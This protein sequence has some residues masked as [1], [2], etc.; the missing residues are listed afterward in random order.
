MYSKY[1]I[2]KMLEIQNKFN[3]REY[4]DNWVKGI[5]TNK[6]RINLGR[7]IYMKASGLMNLYHWEWDTYKEV[8]LNS[9]VIIYEFIS[10]LSFVISSTMSEVSFRGDNIIE[11][12][13]KFILNIKESNLY[14]NL[15]SIEIL[16][17]FLELGLILS[18]SKDTQERKLA[19]K[20][21]FL[22]FN[23]INR[24]FLNNKGFELFMGNH[25]LNNFKISHGLRNGTYN[26][27]LAGVK[28]KDFL[29]KIIN[30]GTNYSDIEVELSKNYEQ[31][32]L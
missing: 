12:A 10:I 7:S 23:E 24:S 31:L 27:T 32:K 26:D 21:L 19:I 4:G 28:D 6:H 13:S 17:N 30:N 11:N 1:Q 8:D 20:N 18:K 5:H 16:E 25:I 29:L 14:S 3:V 2:D 22:L 9:N 15:S